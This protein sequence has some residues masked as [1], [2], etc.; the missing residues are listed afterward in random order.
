MAD[1]KRSKKLIGGIIGGATGVVGGLASNLFGKKKKSLPP[2][3]NSLA[4]KLFE[5]KDSLDSGKT[6]TEQDST[7]TEEKRN[8]K[9]GFFVD[10]NPV[11]GAILPNGG[12]GIITN[13]NNIIP[14]GGDDTGGTVNQNSNISFKISAN[15]NGAAVFVNGENTYKTTPNTLG[16]RLSDVVKDGAKTI[17]LQKEGYVCTTVYV[18]TAIQNPDFNETALDNYENDLIQQDSLIN[19]GPKRNKRIYTQTPAYVFKI[20]QYVDGI[21]QSTDGTLDN[22]EIKELIF[23]INTQTAGQKSDSNAVSTNIL[24]ITLDGPDNSVIVSKD[25]G[26]DF[27]KLVKGRN[28]IVSDI[29]SVYS[30]SS[31][32]LNLYKVNKIVATAEGFKPSTLL[33][34]NLESLTT[35]ITLDSNYAID[36]VSEQFSTVSNSSPAI[37]FENPIQ[38]RKYNINSKAEYPI[39][40]STLNNSPIT[41]ITAFI[42]ES[43]FVFDNLEFAT[44][45][46]LT[47]KTII[48]IP[49]EAFKSIA[50]YK[51]FIVPSNGD[52]DG[53][54]IET[55]ISVV[56]EFYVGV[57]DLRNIIYP[58][59]LVGPDYAGTNVNFDIEYES[60]N[61]D[62]VRIYV[63]DSTTFIQEKS[64]GKLE[65]NLKTLLNVSGTNVS[66]DA[67]SISLI[68]K[69]VPYNISGVEQVIGK[70]EIVKINF[71]KGANQI[72][73]NLAINRIAD[74]FSSQ[75]DDSIFSKET[76]KYL[77]HLLH[78]PDGDTKVITT[79]TGSEGSLI[80]KLYEPIPTTVQPNEEIFISK[81]KL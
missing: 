24:T 38:I 4:G 20:E 67:Q 1:N 41:K 43:K 74:I 36:I 37:Q 73:R 21:L 54:S 46:L 57:P 72:P 47:K 14:L 64:D 70:T 79:W 44:K 10:R 75:L 45:I 25:G 17:S 69:L 2:A 29:G 33:P 65:L 62:F 13:S 59:E 9:I 11:A 52:G 6:I 53:D 49:A 40:I 60:E 16:F 77:T 78:F 48:A 7:T 5:R 61:T 31:A 18:V 28:T 55:S 58:L 80:A 15:Q 66:E 39:T 42:G 76:S 51:V 35:K 3:A 71:N 8:K 30:I 50:N 63:G 68:L 23:K 32:N 19:I 12:V 34:E 27:T 81:L 22:N 26:T 56:D